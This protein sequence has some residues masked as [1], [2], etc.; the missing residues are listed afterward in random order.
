MTDEAICRAAA[1][2]GLF[3]VS[4]EGVSLPSFHTTGQ[5]RVMSWGEKATWWLKKENPKQAH[6][7]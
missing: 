7:N 6:K 3:F 2:P 1:A 5:G 4:H